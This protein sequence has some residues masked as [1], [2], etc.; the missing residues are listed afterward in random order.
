MDRP[1]EFRPATPDD[2][3]ATIA[4]WHD[5]ALVAVHN[6]PAADF[7]F[8]LA[9]PSSTVVLAT[10]G[11]TVVGSVMVGHDGHRGW[12][13][14][15]A[16]APTRRRAGLGRDLVAA[17]ER[18]LAARGVPKVHLMVREDNRAVVGFYERLGYADMPRVL[19]SKWLDPG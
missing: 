17:A 11:A 19:M 8:A 18:W 13:Y 7:A 5:A 2:A 4:L 3:A 12:L 14:Y 9:G 15:L 10:A 16:V 6:D 1:I